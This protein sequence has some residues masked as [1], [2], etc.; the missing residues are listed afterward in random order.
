LILGETVIATTTFYKDPEDIRAHLALKMLDSALDFDFP[1]VVVDGGSHPDFIAQ[2]RKRDAHVFG[3]EAPGMGPGR[4]QALRLASD[5]A[6][7]DGAIVWMEPEKEPLITEIGYC[8]ELIWAGQADM[9]IPK[10]MSLSSYPT[11]QAHAE[12]MGN[13]AFQYMTGH[14]LDIWFGPMVLNRLALQ[15]FLDYDGKY[16][17]KWDSIHIPRLHVIKAGLQ[18]ESVNVDYDHPQEQTKQETGDLSFLIKR[19]DQLQNLVPTFWQEAYE[20]G[21]TTQKPA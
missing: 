16:G 21:L 18:V 19:I 4:R 12:M 6:G 13:L 1:T 14:A 9:V 3:E 8:E 17:D 15:Y 5:M 11:E 2:M 10:R 20:L 7:A